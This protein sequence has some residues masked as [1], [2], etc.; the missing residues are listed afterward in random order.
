MDTNTDPQDLE[1]E[2]EFTDSDSNEGS[3]IAPALVKLGGIALAGATALVVGGMT[4]AGQKLAARLIDGP[5]PKSIRIRKKDA[6]IFETP[7]EIVV[8]SYPDSQK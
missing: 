1:V 7:P 4:I 8:D 6:E 5:R 3:S 2:V